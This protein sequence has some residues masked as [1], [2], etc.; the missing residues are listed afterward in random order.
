MIEL[1]VVLLV[2]IGLA[3]LALPYVNRYINKISNASSAESAAEL[4]ASLQRQQADYDGLP[5][6]LNSLLDNTGNCPAGYLDNTTTQGVPLAPATICG[7][8]ITPTILNFCIYTQNFQKFTCAAA[9]CSNANVIKSLEAAGIKTVAS[10]PY[11][12][13][14][15]N[16]DGTYAFSQT[17]G[18]TFS[19][20]NPTAPLT[21]SSLLVSDRNAVQGLDIAAALNY[22]LPAGHTMIVLGAGPSTAVYAKSLAFAPVLFS[23]KTSL[24][25]DFVYSRFLVAL[26]VDYTHGSPA[27]MIGIVHAPD[28]KVGWQS[29]RSDIEGYYSQ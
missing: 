14:C 24:Q 2:L 10:L 7:P 15:A 11:G 8:G 20:E 18:A 3:G 13:A 12:F 4:L 21:S 6:G 23:A 1:S 27:R 16:A 17:G 25:P 26:D 19:Q 5:N 22:R 29:L 28:I 9:N